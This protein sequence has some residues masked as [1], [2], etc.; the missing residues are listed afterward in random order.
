ME[1]FCAHRANGAARRN[2]P[3][4][5]IVQKRKGPRQRA[6]EHGAFLRQHCFAAWEAAFARR[7][8]RKAAGGKIVDFSPGP[9]RVPGLNGMRLQALASPVAKDCLNFRS[10]GS[11]PPQSRRSPSELV[12]RQPPRQTGSKH[13]HPHTQ[14]STRLFHRMPVFIQDEGRRRFRRGTNWLK[15]CQNGSHAS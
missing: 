3:P 6:H 7:K 8:R 14:T 15:A 13:V 4:S 10:R 2:H 12:E 9:P 5:Q 11:N 1:N